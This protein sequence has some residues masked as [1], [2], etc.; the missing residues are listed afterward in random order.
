MKGF[1]FVELIPNKT[2]SGINKQYD[3]E[4]RNQICDLQVY[5][6]ENEAVLDAS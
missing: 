3:P 5:P 4:E 1:V 6:T 2:A